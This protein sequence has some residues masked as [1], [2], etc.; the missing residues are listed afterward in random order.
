MLG[1]LRDATGE[2]CDLNVG[3]AGVL[4]MQPKSIQIEIVARS[5][6]LEGG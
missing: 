2:Q 3:T 1:Q 4:F 5:H 6:T